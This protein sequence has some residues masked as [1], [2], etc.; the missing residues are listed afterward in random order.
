MSRQHR[1]ADAAIELIEKFGHRSTPDGYV[2]HAVGTFDISQH[3]LE[4]IIKFLKTK[5]TAHFIDERRVIFKTDDEYAAFMFIP[6]DNGKWS[7]DMFSIVHEHET[8]Y[9]QSPIGYHREIFAIVDRAVNFGIR[10]EKILGVDMVRAGNEADL[11]YIFARYGFQRMPLNTTF[12]CLVNTEGHYED[13]VQIINEY[14]LEN[15]MAIL[16]GY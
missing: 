14:H 3:R 8:Q 15:A 10:S 11:S 5:R 12:P 7:M 1:H 6:K 13:D 9:V 16:R 2:R 4:E